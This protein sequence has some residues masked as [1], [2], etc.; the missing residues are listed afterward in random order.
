MAET[1]KKGKLFRREIKYL[2]LATTS[3]LNKLPVQWTGQ[4][5]ISESN[6]FVKLS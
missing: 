3:W 1:Q 2:V 4:A 6:Y 5:K